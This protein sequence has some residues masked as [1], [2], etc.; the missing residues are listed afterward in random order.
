MSGKDNKLGLLFDIHICRKKGDLLEVANLCLVGSFIHFCRQMM[1]Q[2][3]GM[4]CIMICVEMI[5]DTQSLSLPQ[6]AG[7]QGS[8]CRS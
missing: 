5:D 6:L 1:L 2:G 8:V 3:G 7:Y 4:P